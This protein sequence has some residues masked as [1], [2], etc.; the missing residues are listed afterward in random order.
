MKQTHSINFEAKAFRA[1]CRDFFDKNFL[2]YFTLIY[3]IYFI[4]YFALLRANISY[5]DDLRRAVDGVPGFLDP[6]Y[7]YSRYGSEFLTK[8]IH[9]DLT[10]NT[11][12]SPIPQLIA[13]A[14]LSFA[15]L[16]LIKIIIGRINFVSIL[17]TAPVGLSPFY[18]E[19]MSFKFDA[20]FMAI[21]LT[22]MIFPFLFRKRL[23]LFAIISL[24]CVLLMA[25][26]YQA[27]NGIFIIMSLFVAFEMA[28][29]GKK[30]S[31][32]LNFLPYV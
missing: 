2:K 32:I 30:W 28:I 12:I 24:F 8:I 3:G 16:A 15:S 22:S 11:D 20:P 5:K 7:G 6:V 25:T 21:A 31:E 19:N 4:G 18:L 26:T 9:M 14:I 17:A 29:S 1:I 10:F 23:S 27:A 13:L